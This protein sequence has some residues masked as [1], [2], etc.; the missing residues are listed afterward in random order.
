MEPF[1]VSDIFADFKRHDLGP[2]FHERNFD[3]T[4]C[5]RT[6]RIR[7]EGAPQSS[8]QCFSS[9]FA[10][11]SPSWQTR[12]QWSCCISSIPGE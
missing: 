12:T 11:H 4:L 10:T 6:R 9:R 5:S 8:L 1:V 2:A 3:G 7:S